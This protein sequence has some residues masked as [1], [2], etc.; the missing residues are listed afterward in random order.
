MLSAP[1]K[2]NDMYR[3]AGIDV[4]KKLLVV[5]VAELRADGVVILERRKFLATP[6]QMRK[7]AEFLIEWEVEEVVMESTAQYWQ[8][9]WGM[10]EEVW[11]PQRRQRT[12]RAQRLASCTWRRHNRTRQGA[13]ARTIMRMPSAW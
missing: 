11:Q 9:V 10:L 4:H 5:V 7:L 12:E 2:E 8:P 3:I 6:E 1:A 13:V